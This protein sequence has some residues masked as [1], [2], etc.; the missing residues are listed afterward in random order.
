[1]MLLC[2]V[3]MSQSSSDALVAK[4]AL[5]DWETMLASASEVGQEAIAG[6]IGANE[7]WECPAALPIC[8]PKFGIKLA[9]RA[10]ELKYKKDPEQRLTFLVRL[11]EAAEQ[12]LGSEK[13]SKALRRK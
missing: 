8:P 4:S 1:M 6:C 3:Q 12:L 9:W 2:L 10:T 7:K 11:A 5:G 13:W